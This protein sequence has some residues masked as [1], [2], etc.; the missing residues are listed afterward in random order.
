MRGKRKSNLW[1]ESSYIHYFYDFGL[2]EAFS[3]S[4]TDKV[5][6]EVTRKLQYRIRR[7]KV[8]YKSESDLMIMDYLLQKELKRA[9]STKT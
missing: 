5:E 8:E 9:T 1:L 7:G 3:H 6:G 2:E 4:K